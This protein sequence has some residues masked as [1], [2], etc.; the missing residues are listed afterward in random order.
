MSPGAVY[1]VWGVS[2][3]LGAAVLVVVAVLLELI[4]R[5]ALRIEGAVAD[6][7]TAGQGV[8]NNT[9]HIALLHRTNVTAARI[10]DAVGGVLGAGTAIHSH[11]QRCRS[12]PSCASGGAP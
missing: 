4:R 2:L 5:A 8:A 3:L 7:W 11:A 9:I 10:L 12:C 1:T 6:I